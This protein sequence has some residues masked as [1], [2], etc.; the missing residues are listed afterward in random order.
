MNANARLSHDLGCQLIIM[1]NCCLAVARTFKLNVRC[2]RLLEL[3]GSKLNADDLA[4]YRSSYARLSDPKYIFYVSD[5]GLLAMANSGQWPQLEEAARHRLERSVGESVCDYPA[6]SLCYSMKVRCLLASGDLN[7]ALATA[8]TMLSMATNHVGADQLLKYAEL[9]AYVLIQLGEAD[10]AESLL[11]DSVTRPSEDGS[12]YRDVTPFLAQ[13]QVLRG[14]MP[15]AKFLAMS[16]ANHWATSAHSEGFTLIVSVPPVLAV[17]NI[18]LTLLTKR[19]LWI[20]EVDHP[21]IRAATLLT[22]ML[23]RMSERSPSV[24]PI[25]AVYIAWFRCCAPTT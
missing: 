5:L 21:M 3:L 20:C 14:D 17:L 2:C 25:A 6:A 15:Q 1:G 11:S 4:T 7:E 23:H 24:A 10:K 8:S 12:S 19:L 9:N 16:A 18:L 22:S 13:I